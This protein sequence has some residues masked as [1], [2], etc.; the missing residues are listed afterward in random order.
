MTRRKLGKFGLL[1]YSFTIPPL[2]HIHTPRMAQPLSYKR[3]ATLRIAFSVCVSVGITFLGLPIHNG[4][5]SLPQFRGGGFFLGG[6]SIF[7]FP[8]LNTPLIVWGSRRCANKIVFRGG[9]VSSK[10]GWVV[11]FL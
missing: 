1:F 4:M 9:G 11:V 6:G 10:K 7:C 8:P 2:P 5:N 3:K